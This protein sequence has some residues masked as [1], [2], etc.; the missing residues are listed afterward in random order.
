[1]AVSPCGSQERDITTL[2][3]EKRDCFVKLN[4][5]TEEAAFGQI[6]TST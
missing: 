2:R 1:M 4:S 5:S 3:K 6:L